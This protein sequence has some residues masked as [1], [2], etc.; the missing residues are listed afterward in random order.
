MIHQR[1]LV[2]NLNT[3]S[4][5]QEGLQFTLAFILA[6]A[7]MAADHYGQI[8]GNVRN[9]LL[10]TLS[11]IEKMAT[12][13]QDIYKLVTTDFSSIDA[14]KRENQQLKTELLLIKAKQLQMINLE[15]QVQRLEALLGT[16]GKI[17]N[18]NVQIASAIFYSKNPLSQFITLNKGRLDG[19]K[20]QQTV[21]DADGI[22]GQI[23]QITPVT[24]R[25]L[26]LTDPDHQIPVRIQR[27]GQRGILAG[28]G[29]DT[30]QLNFIPVN[31]EIKVGDMLESSGLGGIFPAGYPVAKIT[32]IETLGD[33]PYFQVSAVPV[34]KINQ[35]DKVL[36]VS[37]EEM[38]DW[39]DT[40]DFDLDFDLNINNPATDTGAKP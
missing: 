15:L 2:I 18:Q 6:I 29:H 20:Q 17:T 10:T 5:Q 30:A 25:V 22:I 27:T 26:L 7:L 12:V 13:P 38:Q 37:Q 31:S 39:R 19:V 3:P 8:M 23:V 9:V 36:I 1:R 33:N 28:T 34:A 11:P 32:S 21:I 14:L 40:L 24:A 4:A 35:S 16:T